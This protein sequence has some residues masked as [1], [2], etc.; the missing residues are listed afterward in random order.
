[1][2]EI[3]GNENGSG[4]PAWDVLAEMRETRQNLCLNSTRYGITFLDDASRGLSF[5]EL[6][7]IG[8]AT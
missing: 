5:G 3:T 7:V 4:I 6:V 2:K 8:A 1:V